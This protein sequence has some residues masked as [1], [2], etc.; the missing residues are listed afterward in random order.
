M[1][2]A[3][4]LL[5]P[6]TIHT[7]IPSFC[8][9][10]IVSGDSFLISSAM[11]RTAHAVPLIPARMAVFPS[12]SNLRMKFSASGDITMLSRSA[13]ARLPIATVILPLMTPDAP[14]PVIAA[15]SEGCAN[16]LDSNTFPIFCSAN[17]TMAVAK[18]CSEFRSSE[19]NN[20]SRKSSPEMRESPIDE[21]FMRLAKNSS[22]ATRVKSVTAGFPFVRV[23]VLSKSTALTFEATS[24]VSP[25][26]MRIP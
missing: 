1:A 3:V 19:P 26:F 14:R 6:V 11:P 12:S 10:R 24:S 17:L 21:V 9:Y 22:E 8:R 2:W 4:R 15:K 20:Q 23:P 25:P 5:S 13:K 7:S 16:G 18:I